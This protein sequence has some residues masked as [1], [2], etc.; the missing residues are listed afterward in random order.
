[1][2]IT[3]KTKRA[4]DAIKALNKFLDDLK[5]EHAQSAITG[6]VPGATPKKLKGKPRVDFSK[7]KG[8][9]HKD[10]K[11]FGG[12]RR[13]SKPKNQTTKPKKLRSF[14]DDVDLKTLSAK[15][16]AAAAMGIPAIGGGTALA[17]KTKTNKKAG[18]GKV[19]MSHQGL[20]PAEEAR[21]G[22]MSEME[23]AKN[24]KKGGQV[25]KKQQGYKDRK[26]ES[27]AMRVKKKRTK[28]QLKASANES[29]GKFGSAAKKRGKIN[30]SSS[31][32]FDGN[33]EVSRHY[34]S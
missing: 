30:R 5:M 2:A 33:R 12:P 20:Y 3:G 14:L 17:V 29:Y 26:D 10:P 25:K 31:K 4:S 1:M 32:G 11:D 27:I 22:T 23:R 28:K 9:D 6:K 24:M 7:V 8:T 21:S 34:D 16:K 13:R 15:D 19:G 18:G